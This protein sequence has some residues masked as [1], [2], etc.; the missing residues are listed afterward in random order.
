M[1][2]QRTATVAACTLLPHTQFSL[3]EQPGT[4]AGA[5]GHRD[6]NSHPFDLEQFRL[7]VVVT[8]FWFAGMKPGVSPVLGKLSGT[9]E[10]RAKHLG[11]MS[12]V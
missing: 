11:F 6:G 10:G 8:D 1:L 3:R 4:Q 12:L 9:T 5:H 7:V 2:A